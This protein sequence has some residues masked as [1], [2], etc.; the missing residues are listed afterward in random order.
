MINTPVMISTQAIGETAGAVWQYLKNHGKSTIR[1]V[2][3]EVEAPAGMVPMAIGWL[4]REG[5]L[6]VGQE[7]RSVYAWLIES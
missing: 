4:A 5:K 7:R 2:E 3:R 6:E 1:T